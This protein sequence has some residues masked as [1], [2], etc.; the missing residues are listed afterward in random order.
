MKNKKQKDILKKYEQT[1]T[2][3]NKCFLGKYR[4]LKKINK[5]A[6]AQSQNTSKK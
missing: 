5:K 6:F 1:L 3:W 2:T 4:I